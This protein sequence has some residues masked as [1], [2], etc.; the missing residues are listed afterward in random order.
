MVQCLLISLM[1][2]PLFH[3]FGYKFFHYSDFFISVIICPTSFLRIFVV[4]LFLMPVISLIFLY[5]LK[6]LYLLSRSS[7]FL[8]LDNHFSIL[9]SESFFL[10]CATLLCICVFFTLCFLYFLSL[11]GFKVSFLS[12]IETF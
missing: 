3:L 12:E 9:E 6:L 11:S 2:D 1:T 8:H 10:C 4:V 5:M 7:I